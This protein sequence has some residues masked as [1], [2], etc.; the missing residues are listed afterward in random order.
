MSQLGG[1]C[2]WRPGGALP[3]PPHRDPVTHVNS[4]REERPCFRSPHNLGFLGR[5]EKCFGGE[6]QGC[7]AHGRLMEV[8]TL[9]LGSERG[10]EVAKCGGGA[11][12]VQKL[13]PHFPHHLSPPLCSQTRMN[14]PCC[15]RP[16]AVPPATIHSVASTAS[17]PLALTLTKPWVAARMWM[18][19]QRGGDP[20]ATAVPTPPV[21][22]CAAAL[23]ATS[24]LGK[25]EGLEWS[26]HSP[27]TLVV[28]AH[29]QAHAHT[30]TCMCTENGALS[31]SSTCKCAHI[32][33]HPT[34]V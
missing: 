29:V 33:S 17:V 20:V 8:L 3:C 12:P 1:G 26:G 5:L 25:G 4:A 10:A 9:A 7:R 18:S 16:A 24:G 13:V 22:S 30:R 31:P 19:V 32:S 27:P 15:L 21:A 11:V 23:E 28:Y 34:V 2:S 6:L 14:V